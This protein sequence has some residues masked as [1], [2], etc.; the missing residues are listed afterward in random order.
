MQITSNS[1]HGKANGAF[2]VIL[3]LCLVLAGMYFLLFQKPKPEVKK[4]VEAPVEVV[5]PV[6]VVEPEVE[7]VVE[8]EPEP[9]VEPEPV[10]EPEPEP[11]VKE[12]SEVDKYLEEK[13]PFPK[14]RS[15]ESLVNNWKK[16]PKNAF[17]KE[18]TVQVS[19]VYINRSKTAKESQDAGHLA[20]PVNLSSGKLTLTLPENPQLGTRVNID[21][22]NFKEKVRELYEHKIE[23]KRQRLIAKREA[24]REEAIAF[25]KEEASNSSDEADGV[26]KGKQS[27][28]TKYAHDGYWRDL[29]PSIAGEKIFGSPEDTSLEEHRDAHAMYHRGD[30]VFTP[31]GQLDAYAIASRKYKG[32]LMYSIEHGG[33]LAEAG[34][35]QWDTI[36]KVNTSTLPAN[37]DETHLGTP[38]I[39]L[40]AKNLIEA[41]ETG[42]ILTLYVKRESEKKGQPAEKL[43]FDIKVAKKGSLSPYLERGQF[44]DRA[45]EHSLEAVQYLLDTQQENGS[46]KCGYSSQLSTT[47]AGTHLIMAAPKHPEMQAKILRSLKKATDYLTDK[48]DWDWGWDDASASW[49]FAEYFWATADH[50]MYATFHDYLNRLQNTTNPLGGV[51]H[52]SWGA[53]YGCI[54]LGGPSGLA[55]IALKASKWCR[56][57]NYSESNAQ[58]MDGY[59][60]DLMGGRNA[61]KANASGYMGHVAKFGNIGADA[62]NTGMFLAGTHRVDYGKD[63]YGSLK[64]S[65]S[66]GMYDLLQEGTLQVNHIHATPTLG[67]I[68]TAIGLSAVDKDEKSALKHSLV[69]THTW[70][71][72][73]SLDSK[74]RFQY[75]YPRNARM[76]LPGGGGWNGDSLMG[77]QHL[78]AVSSLAMLHAPSKN[79][80]VNAKEKPSSFGWLNPK[81]NPKD[82]WKKVAKF[83]QD[84]FD[85]LLKEIQSTARKVESLPQSLVLVDKLLDNYP[86]AS[87]EF[88]YTRDTTKVLATVIKLADRAKLQ[89]PDYATEE[90]E[91]FLKKN[92]YAEKPSEVDG[93]MKRYKEYNKKKT[94]KQL[95]QRVKEIGS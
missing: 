40:F 87:F 44:T 6:V 66:M 85:D 70:K 63:P 74:G 48:Q 41:E 51:T 27:S 76:A 59:V 81:N 17:P 10:I 67:T 29:S 54:N 30:I 20:K 45:A 16:V 18:V 82:A 94:L 79:L 32:L 28:S 36:Y 83:H 12:K 55:R 5:K 58:L 52:K 47:L 14:F 92:A 49:F 38:G 33:L 84:Q 34:I 60:F 93:W 15:L 90:V 89:M 35:Q 80:L 39:R 57:A 75:S 19:S 26:K 68:F 22:T 25:L 77:L 50:K 73:L 11:V 23:E 71:L 86:P 61:D 69:Q 13:F 8:P 21:D 9:V 64:K 56:G 42:G 7:P 78:A 62:M 88:L 72:A 1:R 91:T 53:P 95:T 3:V 43:K 46:W 4:L 2:I 24:H 65:L 37:P 31:M